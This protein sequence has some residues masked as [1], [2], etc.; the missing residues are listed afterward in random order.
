MYI[1]LNIFNGNKAKLLTDFFCGVE[2][3]R[4]WKDLEAPFPPFF[5]S[6]SLCMSSLDPREW[7]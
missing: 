1:I 4:R 6:P 7:S 2:V 3:S 5:H